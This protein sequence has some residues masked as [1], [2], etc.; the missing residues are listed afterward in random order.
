MSRFTTFCL[1][2]AGMQC[3]CLG[4][5]SQEFRLE[6]HADRVNIFHG[7]QPV[8][9]Y[10]FSDRE[11]LRPYL[12]HLKT[13]GGIQ[14]SRNHP[15]LKADDQDH[16]TMHPGIWMAFGD[17]N[18]LDFWRNRAKVNNQSLKL[19][20]SS[21]RA[22]LTA[23]NEYRDQGGVTC[24]EECR[25]SFY[26]IKSGYLI[27]WDSRFHSGKDF[28]FG[29]QEEMGL[30]MRL[31]T[32][33]AEK[34]GG[35]MI[36]SEG[37]KSARQIWGNTARWI[38]YHAIIDQQLVGQ[39]LIPHPGNFRPSWMHARNYGFVAAN[40]FGRHAFGKG[41]KSRVQVKAG[42][43]LRLRY[44]ILLHSSDERKLPDFDAAYQAY[45]SVSK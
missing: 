38:D 24:M 42:D 1:V 2:L 39:M 9:V 34:R 7:K 27:S 13:P 35:R 31:A 18:G 15:P 22:S 41:K 33:I 26:R 36:D 3:T 11:I 4:G 16:A 30:G 6:R 28:Y 32:P 10:V 43:S 29:D 12:A 23:Q 45:L 14:S 21:N 44:G 19:Q 5:Y 37:R 17:L 25:I 40:P 20:T 8:A